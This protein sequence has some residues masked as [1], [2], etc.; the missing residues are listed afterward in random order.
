MAIDVRAEPKG[1]LADDSTRLIAGWLARIARVISVDESAKFGEV[2]VVI[3]PAAAIEEL[4]AKYFNDPTPTDV[5]TFPGESNRDGA[6]TVGDIAICLDV[7]REQA[8]DAGHSIEEE[9]VF[10]A[11]H[12][13]LHLCGWDDQTPGNRES[14]L[15]RQRYLMDRT[16]P[17]ASQVPPGC[18]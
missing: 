12:G 2:A 11:T 17:A 13:L 14:M 1:L 10:L 7:A 3:V 8:S 9:I 4:H 18:G 6:F 15:Q 5:I 16:A